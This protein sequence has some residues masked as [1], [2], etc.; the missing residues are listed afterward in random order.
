[1]CAT[2]LWALI[3]GCVS[4]FP[5]FFLHLSFFALLRDAVLSQKE[6]QTFISIPK[7]S[8]NLPIR[9]FEHGKAGMIIFWWFFS[10]PVMIQTM[11]DVSHA[12]LSTCLQYIGSLEVGRPGSRVEIVAAMRRIRVRCS[13][14]SHDLQALADGGSIR[15]VAFA[16]HLTQS[17]AGG[18]IQQA[19]RARRRSPAAAVAPPSRLAAEQQRI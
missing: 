15:P 5:C 7:D 16:E 13:Q 1:M 14:R 9:R 18:W 12:S 8:E 11:E 4:W 6:P 19:V 2:H 3:H 17:C 10:P